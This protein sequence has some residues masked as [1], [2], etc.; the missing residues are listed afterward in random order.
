[1]IRDTSIVLFVLIGAMFGFCYRKWPGIVS[2]VLGFGS[3]AKSL[4]AIRARLAA[5]PPTY[6]VEGLLPDN[7]IHIGVGD[8]SL[9]KTP[10]AYQLGLCVANGIP[11][12]GLETKK[13][14]VIYF[15]AENSDADI[16][17]MSEALASFLKISASPDD[18]LVVTEDGDMPTIE[19]QIKQFSPQLVIVDTLK[20]TAPENLKVESIDA[21]LKY[22]KGVARKYKCAIL[23]LHHIRKPGENEIPALE[24]EKTRVIDWLVQAAGSKSLINLT[25][26]RIAFDVPRSSKATND[27]D[28]VFKANIK[29]CGDSAACLLE[30]KYDE[31]G[32][33]VGYQRLSGLHL[34]GNPEQEAAYQ[35]LPKSRK[36][37]FKEAKQIYGGRGDDPVR[38]WLRKCIGMGILKQ[39]GWGV[40]VCLPTPGGTNTPVSVENVE[41]SS[42]YNHM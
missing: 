5:D 34:L 25:T 7:D 33:P 36:F 19:D 39:V 30:R 41:N 35:R 2:A 8:S 40:Y 11:F 1:M 16:I 18:F 23:L 37:E 26:T 15:D 3:D 28:L 29:T 9:G 17:K 10:W 38:K 20:S 13:S 31:H 22:L 6:I 21:Y 12:L 27:I 14:K 4:D 42:K 24:W 32:E